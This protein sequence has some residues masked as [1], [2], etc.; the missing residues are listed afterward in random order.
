MTANVPKTPSDPATSL[1]LYEILVRENA[2]SLTAFLRAATDDLF[3][4]E[5]IFQET[6][7][8]AWKNLERY[9]ANRPFG[10]WLRGIAKTLLLA[11]A[12]KSRHEVH[13]A[14]ERLWSDLDRRFGSIDR[15]DG[16]DFSEKI[17]AIDECIEAL[18][19]SFR[20][21]IRLFYHKSQTTERVAEL[22][23]SSKDAVQKRL[24][25]ARRDIAD[26]LKRKGVIEVTER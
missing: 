10:A 8:V 3:A 12:R 24:Q 13:G 1:R 6:M 25:R 21:P 15:R 9:D 5:D 17:A 19:P 7:L 18:D 11:H 26:C 22:L 4:A 23:R 2:D 20:E 14:D 16:D